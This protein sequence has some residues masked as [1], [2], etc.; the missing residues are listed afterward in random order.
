[1]NGTE[2]HSLVEPLRGPTGR[3]VLKHR[4]TLRR[5]LREHGVRNPRLFGSVA[6]GV[7]REGSDVDLLV[8]LPSGISLFG[9]LR[10]QEDLESVLGVAV[11]LVPDAGLRDS[12]RRD[13]QRDL[14][15]L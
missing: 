4:E 1:M 11:D 5:M 7:D 14:I 13:V 10:L 6:R 9:I 12:V 8:D 3:L 15:P 2:T